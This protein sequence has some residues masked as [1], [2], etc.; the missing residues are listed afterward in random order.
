MRSFVQSLCL[1]LLLV[2][3]G[4]VTPIAQTQTTY[5]VLHSFTG[6][7]DGGYPVSGLVR[8]ASGTLYGAT[9]IG[10]AAGQGTVFKVDATGQETTLYGFQL[11]PDG[12]NPEASLV[13]DKQGN[14]YGTTYGGGT[15]SA[16][17]VFKIDATGAES[18]LYSFTGG[19]D[20]GYPVAGLL[21][22][23]SGN[24]YGTASGGG[25]TSIYKFGYGVAFKL[26][27]VVSRAYSTPSATVRTGD[28]P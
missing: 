23:A 18:V 1:S 10:G 13:L 5:K 17:S 26:K 22:D 27:H 15:F 21:R 2:V 14:L 28:S 8:D 19:A 9:S 24:L 6:G 12:E 25:D 4:F 16:G 20:G 7:T 3:V 11:V